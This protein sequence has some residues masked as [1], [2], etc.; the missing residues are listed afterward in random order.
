M[1]SRRIFEIGNELQPFQDAVV[2]AF[3]AYADNPREQKAAWLAA[4]DRL[5]EAVEGYILELSQLTPNS[6]H[7]LRQA[8]AP[9][10]Q[11]DTWFGDKP[12]DF[13]RNVARYDSFNDKLWTKYSGMERAPTNYFPDL[14]DTVEPVAEDSPAP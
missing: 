3:E 7:T 6:E 1:N 5:N 11:G 2:S 8:F 9:K 13:L 14:G 4:V 12:A 10:G